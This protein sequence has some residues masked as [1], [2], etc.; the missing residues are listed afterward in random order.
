MQTNPI[1]IQSNS[2]YGYVPQKPGTISFQTGQVAEQL[3][4]QSPT[5]K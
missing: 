4:G 1:Q 2:Q 5:G 3:K